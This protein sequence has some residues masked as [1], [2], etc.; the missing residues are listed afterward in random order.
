M[1]MGQRRAALEV[2]RRCVETAEIVDVTAGAAGRTA[3]DVQLLVVE[4]LMPRLVAMLHTDTIKVAER[5]HR[6]CCC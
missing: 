1:P 6:Y 2:L 5:L 4:K 3:A